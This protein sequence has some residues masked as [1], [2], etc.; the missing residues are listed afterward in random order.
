MG[1]W[2]KYEF[3]EELKTSLIELIENGELDNADNVWGYIH[4][5]IDNTC[6]YTSTCFEIAKELLLYDF[7]DFALG[8]ATSISQ[9]AYY[10]L[11]EYIRDEFDFTEIALLIEEKNNEL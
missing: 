2:N 3:L 7:T 9:L 5:E 8:T 10:G 6:I 1:N 4:C 11:D